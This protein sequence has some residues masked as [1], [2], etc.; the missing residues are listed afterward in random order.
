LNHDIDDLLIG[1]VA[2]IKAY[3]SEK[4]PDENKPVAVRKT[5]TVY[6]SF[7]LQVRSESMP[8]QEPEAFH[9]AIRRFSQRKKRQM[10]ASAIIDLEGS[11]C[12][13]LSPTGLFERF[14]RWRKG[15]PKC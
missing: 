14:R 2:E 5:Q 4:V 9:A 3:K 11:K 8:E 15:A 1:I 7:D 10:G 6:R 12:T 13:N